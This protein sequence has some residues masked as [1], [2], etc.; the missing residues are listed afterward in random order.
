M[1][2]SPTTPSPDSEMSDSPRPR[3]F[4]VR[5]DGTLTPLV[6]VD[7]LPRN[8]R[9]RGVPAVVSLADTQGMISLGVVARS[10][11]RYILERSSYSS[12]SRIG[13]PSSGQP[14]MIARLDATE[15]HATIRNGGM[16]K[17]ETSHI[18]YAYGTKPYYQNAAVWVPGQGGQQVET[19]RQGIPS[20]VDEIQVRPGSSLIGPHH[21]THSQAAV[22]AIVDAASRDEIV[23]A[24][25]TDTATA[26]NHPTLPSSASTHA[27]RQTNPSSSHAANTNPTILP[28]FSSSPAATTA[29][30]NTLLPPTSNSSSSPTPSPKK[31][32][33]VYCSFWIRRGECDYTQQGCRYKHE[34]PTDRTTLRDLG[35]TMIPRW[36]REANAV[37][38]GGSGW[39]E[40]AGMSVG[41]EREKG[42]WRA[43]A[44][45]NAEKALGAQAPATQA[46][47][48]LPPPQMKATED[49]RTMVAAQLGGQQFSTP[50]GVA[51]G[52]MT[53]KSSPVAFSFPRQMMRSRYSP[54]AHTSA[55]ILATAAAPVFSLPSTPGP[56]LRQQYTAV[57]PHGNASEMPAPSPAGLPFTGPDLSPPSAAAEM[58][59]SSFAE[60]TATPAAPA[61]ATG[62]VTPTQ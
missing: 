33:K 31:K 18:K 59:Q 62:N 39:N 56:V 2:R 46:P 36:W 44:G 60:G 25:A 26:T 1:S 40:R 13:T 55:P 48:T 42:M 14:A 3:Y 38:V 49:M 20:G 37:K 6:A 57:T 15:E 47:H 58:A 32:E 17:D 22:D 4:L 61:P 9:I 12:P 16:A 19:W 23:T 52:A 35:I 21:L 29:T 7:E 8:I 50:A 24:G 28:P 10:E 41:K 53:P 34:M 45:P 43:G 51:P 30:S 27:L 11:C 5:N 54:P